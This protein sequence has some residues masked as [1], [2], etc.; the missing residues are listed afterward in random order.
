MNIDDM[1]AG[2]KMDALVEKTL[3][4]SAII[5]VE[6]GDGCDEPWTSVETNDGRILPGVPISHYSTDDAAACSALDRIREVKD[7]CWVVIRNEMLR[8]N[9]EIEGWRV[10]LHECGKP[11]IDRAAIYG[12]AVAQ[13]RPLAISRAI[14]KASG[15]QEIL[16]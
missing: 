1:P 6:Y 5:W 14:L 3:W 11:L 9:Y 13:D 4:P 12:T 8:P 7:S 2:R 16:S 10:I 15:V